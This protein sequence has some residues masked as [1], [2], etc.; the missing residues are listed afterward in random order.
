M[1][2]KLILILVAL[3]ALAGCAS[4]PTEYTSPC[5]CGFKPINQQIEEDEKATV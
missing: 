4:I 2:K 5:A 1:S 3:S